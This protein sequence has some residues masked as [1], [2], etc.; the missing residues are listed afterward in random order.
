MRVIVRELDFIS[1]SKDDFLKYLKFKFTMIHQSNFFYR[2][3]HYGLLS[4]LHEHGHHIDGLQANNVA[5]TFLKELEQTGIAK[6][7]DHQTWMLNYP[8]FALPRIEKKSA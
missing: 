5:N 4:F 1:N 8:E 2:D 6:K 3:F 7:I